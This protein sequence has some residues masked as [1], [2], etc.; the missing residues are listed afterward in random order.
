MFVSGQNIDYTET[1]EGEAVL[2]VPG[3]F[4]TPAAWRGII[5]RMGAGYRCISTSLCGYGG[6]GETRTLEDAAMAHETR[7]IEAVAKR[8]G[9]PVHLVG[10]SFGATVALAAALQGNIELRSITTFEAN[11]ARLLRHCGGQASFV[12]ARNISRALEQAHF[13]G[14]AEAAGIVIDFWGGR[15]SFA[16][17]PE[18]VRDYCRAGTVTNALDWRTA[19]A[20][21][22][23]ASDL[24][25]LDVPV[26][27]VRGEHANSVMVEV[28]D[29]LEDFIP[30]ARAEVV[31]GA[32]HFLITTHVDDC[33]DL[34][35]DFL[36]D[37]AA[38]DHETPRVAAE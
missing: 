34:L 38:R 15:G 20:F 16:A 18:P 11:P 12:Y 17:M 28:T 27:L 25:G 19:L 21:D 2:F 37:V 8:I 33:A 3:S 35:L 22:V 5:D 9:E 1:G 23:R 26:M 10:H 31:D 32:S 24:A 4:S 13:S 14:E 36:A 7:I 6:T 29:R 30:D